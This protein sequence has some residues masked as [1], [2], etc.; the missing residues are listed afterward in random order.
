MTSLPARGLYAITSEALCREPQ[1]L[2]TA[3]EAALR[4]GATMIQYRDKWNPPPL[5]ASLARALHELC[6]A[7]GAPLLIND[8]VDLALAVG[9]DG[10]HVGAGDTP[11]AAAR[12][13]LGAN[14]I[15]GATCGDSLVRAQAARDASADYVAFGRLF[16]SRTK[17]LAPPARLATLTAARAIGLPVCA[18]GGITPENAAQA[19]AAGADLIAAIDGVFGAGDVE[20]AARAYAPAFTGAT[21]R[22]A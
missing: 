12:A 16:P 21:G 18:I 4:G 14:A 20:A 11:V 7:H 8:D 17:P 15:V 22:I 9:A 13:R 2:L 10:V 1:R 3:I 19:V 5:R 6:R